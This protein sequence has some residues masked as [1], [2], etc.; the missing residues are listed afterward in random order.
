[1]SGGTWTVIDGYKV[2]FTTDKA[3]LVKKGAEEVWV[4]RS[5]LQDHES[6]AIGDTDL[7]VATW[8]VARE[9]LDS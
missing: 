5:C 7:T 9:G 3:V 1:M 4:P 8:F 6:L 2:Q